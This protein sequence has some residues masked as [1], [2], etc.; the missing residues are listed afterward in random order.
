VPEYY[1]LHSAGNMIDSVTTTLEPHE[2]QKRFT[3]FSPAR[4]NP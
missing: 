1:G 3:G 2:E 4:S